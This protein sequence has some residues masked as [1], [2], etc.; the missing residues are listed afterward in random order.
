[1]LDKIHEFAAR[2][3]ELYLNPE[4]REPEVE[5]G[6]GEQCFG[7]GL[8][9]DCGNSFTEAY[10]MEPFCDPDELGKIVDRIDDISLLGSAIFSKW[11]GIT[12]WSQSSLLN[13][14]N[15]RWFIIAFSRLEELS[16]EQTDVFA[17][18]G[19]ANNNWDTLIRSTRCGCF[20]CLRMFSPKEIT[21]WTDNGT[22]AV[23][24]YCGI[25]SVIGDKSCWPVTKEFLEKMKTY[26]F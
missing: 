22:T 14:E 26:W 2:Y 5:K 17:A 19:F 1:M 13:D 4:T 3:L 21:R 23:C 18:H 20:Y 7:L 10:S 12:H 16:R 24:P 15:R 9:M 11:R 25:D 8:R 6:F